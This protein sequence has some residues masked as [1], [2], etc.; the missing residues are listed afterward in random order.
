MI[1]GFDAFCLVA[2][3]EGFGIFLGGECFVV[4]KAFKLPDIRVITIE[5]LGEKNTK[6]KY[7]EIHKNLRI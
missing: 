2:F 5:I 1:I 4:T 6:C 7:S 3:S